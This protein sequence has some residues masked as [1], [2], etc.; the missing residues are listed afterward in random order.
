MRRLEELIEKRSTDEE[1][2]DLGY[3]SVLVSL[4]ARF[5][6]EVRDTE[7]AVDYLQEY[8]AL[9]MKIGGNI[10]EHP[11]VLALKAFAKAFDHV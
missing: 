11:E 8:K 2:T 10:S 1:E 3:R 4:L 5:C 9:E 6:L 7:K